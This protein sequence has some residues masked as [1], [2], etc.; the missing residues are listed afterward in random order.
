MVQTLLGDFQT[1]SQY[2]DIERKRAPIRQSFFK[3]AEVT[4]AMKVKGNKSNMKSLDFQ[5]AEEYATYRVSGGLKGRNRK[6]P[7]H[8]QLD[9]LF[10]MLKR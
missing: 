10:H 6:T 3:M 9:W 7:L 2:E 5:N 1:R 4:K 8:Q